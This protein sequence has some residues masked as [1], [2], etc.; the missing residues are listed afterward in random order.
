MPS[1][2]TFVAQTR[3]LLEKKQKVHR[4]LN[5][6]AE[7]TVCGLWRSAQL[8]PPFLSATKMSEVTCKN[9]KKGAKGWGY[10]DLRALH[11]VT[12]ALFDDYVTEE[13]YPP[14]TVRKWKTGSVIKTRGGEWVPYRMGSKHVTTKAPDAGHGDIVS[15][16]G[17]IAKLREKGSLPKDVSPEEH[18]KIAQEVLSAQHAQFPETLDT[19]RDLASGDGAA[20]MGRVK[21][22]ESAL[23]KLVRKPKYGT[24]RGLMD[25]TGFRVVCES[26]DD[27]LATVKKVK[28]RYETSAK[29]EEDY[30]TKPK[31][32]YRS[33][34]LIIKD[35]DGF[36][37]EVQ[38][39]T[40]HQDTWAN[41]C[42]DVYKPRT[43]DQQKAIAS[44]QK[45]ILE[46]G[47]VMSDYYFEKDQGKQGTTKPPPCPP[48]VEKTFGCLP[49]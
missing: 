16:T 34:H 8:D 26:V 9:C 13:T 30:I 49:L 31:D 18:V 27:V 24:A 38:I 14:G 20:V 15:T 19:L 39:R 48:V 42:H 45:E 40:P 5:G 23:G 7:Q 21:E 32:G 47:K 43:P 10:E 1:L 35:D 25:A 11:R 37:K 17:E 41:W 46:Y 44:S 2:H 4:M 3:A 29:D 36:F 28:E 22:L 33:Y 6:N 12:V